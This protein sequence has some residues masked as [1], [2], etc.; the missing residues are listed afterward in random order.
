M[1]LDRVVILGCPN[2]GKSALFNRFVHRKAAIVFDQPGVT[3]DCY[4][5]VVD[6]ASR[7][8]VLVDTPGIPEQMQNDDLSK[9]MHAQTMKMASSAEIILFMFDCTRQNI[10]GDIISNI[11]KIGKKIIP[12]AN[13]C[14]L[15]KKNYNEQYVYEF[16]M[17]PLFVS[18][19]HGIGIESLKGVIEVALKKNECINE[20]VE[21]IPSDTQFIA[22]D[23]IKISIIGRPNVGKSTLI[24]AILGREAQIVADTPGVTRDVV[25]FDIER[26]GYSFQVS[27]T[28]GVR[29]KAKMDNVLEKISVS[30]TMT[31]INFAHV[32][33]LVI[34]APE[35]ERTDYHELLHQ[36]FFLAANI[37]KEGRCTVIALNKWDQVKNKSLL[38]FRINDSLQYSECKDLFV[39]PTSAKNKTGLDELLH[40][41]IEA[42]KIWNKRIPTSQLNKWL[43]DTVAKN[44]PPATAMFRSKLKYITQTGTRPPQFVIF[45]TKIDKIPSHYSKFLENQLR[46]AFILKSSPIR[47]QWRQQRNPY[48]TNS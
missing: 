46:Q 34:D 43:K 23:A 13:K 7:Q 28:A 36:D 33:V 20:H 26:D 22:K 14:D 27:D 21:S 48:S 32:C 37:I 19:E 5:R 1:P 31:S 17:D 39:V 30:K 38:K 10:S 6:L 40:S 3:R 24:N 4:E 41:I 12:V 16:G 15:L 47:I 29:R 44:P 35:V 11:R 18:A 8:I 9:I 25:E 45:G 42:E 2:V